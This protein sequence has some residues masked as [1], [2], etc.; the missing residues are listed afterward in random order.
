MAG[1]VERIVVQATP[2]E[3]RAIAAKAR[4]LG[5]PISELMRRGG[6]RQAGWR[7]TAV[8][9]HTTYPPRRA[10]VASDA[11][12][13]GYTWTPPGCKALLRCWQAGEDCRHTSGLQTR[14]A[15]RP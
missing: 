8:T 14:D 13:R 4:R 1:A 9:L 6:R 12:R 11:R 5:L 15:L 10:F 2:Q 7:T 3:K